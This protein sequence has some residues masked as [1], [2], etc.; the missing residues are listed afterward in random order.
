MSKSESYHQY[1][2]R[3]RQLMVMA[4]DMAETDRI[5]W[6]IEGLRHDL[7][8]KCK[9]Q[10]DGSTWHSLNAVITFGAGEAHKIEDDYDTDPV[11]AATHVKR[12][13]GNKRRHNHKTGHGN[14]RPKPDKP[15][16]SKSKAS[17][18]CQKCQQPFS[19]DFLFDHWKYECVKNPDRIPRPR[20]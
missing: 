18:K 4:T 19:G 10:L 7:R 9:F 2:T 5:H 16:D 8:S 13:S 1:V 14:K 3:Y 17:R 15:Y 6:F 12:Y 11:L 20:A